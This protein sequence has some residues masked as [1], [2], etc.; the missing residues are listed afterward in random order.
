[1]S[2]DLQ[3]LKDYLQLQIDLG[4]SDIFS[5]HPESL[6]EKTKTALVVRRKK[7]EGGVVPNS[8]Q[9]PS[10]VKTSAMIEIAQKACDQV[11]S[12][13]EL[14]QHIDEFDGSELK[15]MATN[16][17]FSDGNPKASVML[18]GEAPGADEDREGKPFVGMS[19]QLL[20]KMFG[21]IGL[22]R[23]ENLYITNILPYRPPGNR[24][25]T[26]Q[27]MA[28]FRPFVMKHIELIAPKILILVGATA[29]KTIFQ[30]DVPITKMRGQW[31]KIDV[32]GRQIQITSIYHPAY[33]L[34]SPLQKR[35]VWQ[36]LLEI[37]EKLTKGF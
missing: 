29:L 14:R 36:D 22:S 20:D 16:L 21:C 27:E 33:L 13:E 31:D 3:G 34:R 10:L 9:K 30:K 25:P 35:T 19:G 32:S 24:T 11:S 23:S 4:V 37:N 8:V 28:M 17:V 2:Y 18:I 15:K 7:Q 12:L 26:P 6:F 1:M 5:L